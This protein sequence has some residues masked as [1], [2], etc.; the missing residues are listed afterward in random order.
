MSGSECRALKDKIEMEVAET[1]TP[2]CE[3]CATVCPG[4]MELESGLCRV[5]DFIRKKQLEMDKTEERKTRTRRTMD[6]DGEKR[7]EKTVP[8]V[9]LPFHRVPYVF[10][11]VS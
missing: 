7:T 5:V 9:G 8:A 4:R 1:I 3:R 6:E 10:Q 11:C 2:R